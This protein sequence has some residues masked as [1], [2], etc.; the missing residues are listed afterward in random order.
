VV[1]LHAAALEP[2]EVAIVDGL[3]VT[4]VARTV[5]DLARFLP[6]EPALVPADGALH[7]GLV[8]PAAHRNP[9]LHPRCSTR[10]GARAAD[11]RDAPTSTGRSSRPSV[12]ST[13][14]SSTAGCCDPGQDPGDAVFE[15]KV[16]E[17]KVRE[18]AMRAEGLGMAR[19]TWTELQAFEPVSN[20]VRRAFLRP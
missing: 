7:R 12:S 11:G 16:F 10:Y 5:T 3:L 1:H 18:D 6:S 20:R 17:E 14:G 2:D 15:E 13:G 19:W 9:H 8:T 4:S